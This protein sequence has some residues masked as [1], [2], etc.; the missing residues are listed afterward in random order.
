MSGFN[1][2]DTSVTT[3]LKYGLNAAAEKR[4]ATS[5]KK[6]TA[7]IAAF[8]DEE[9]D[10][11]AL[12]GT[13]SSEMH[14][15]G[16]EQVARHQLAA[17]QDAR[18]NAIREQALAQDASVFEYDAHHDS[19]QS[20][21][22]KNTQTTDDER[23]ARKSRY[24][25]TL[26]AKRDEREKEEEILRERRIIKEREKEDHLYR[27]KDKFVTTAYKEKLAADKGW[28]ERDQKKDDADGDVGNKKDMSGFYQNFLGGRNS[29]GDA[30]TSAVV[31]NRDTAHE[32][33]PSAV[34]TSYGQTIA[35][36]ESTDEARRLR[37]AGVGPAEN[38]R[39]T[40][41]HT[42]V[43]THDDE[44]E[45]AKQMEREREKER[46]AAQRAEKIKLARQRYLERKRK[47]T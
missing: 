21:K 38:A 30:S 37:A 40:S 20:Q 5:Q 31:E 26:M 35:K 41:E 25:A 10:D 3:S 36:H 42:N 43:E 27:D 28:V 23:L 24:V 14:R 47:Q 44:Y 39:E 33:A 16:N 9:T 12:A 17:K 22:Q 13:E 34:G 6:P 46:A 15:R 7:P 2:G 29:K 32:T 19:H 18:A 8:A 45:V 11:G 1:L 4:K